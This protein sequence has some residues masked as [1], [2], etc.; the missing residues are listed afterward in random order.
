MKNTIIRALGQTPHTFDV[1]VGLLVGGGRLGAGRGHPAREANFWL[2]D[3]LKHDL[4]HDIESINQTM[5]LKSLLV[6]S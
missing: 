5:Q 4:P 1:M 6:Y 2:Q 3:T